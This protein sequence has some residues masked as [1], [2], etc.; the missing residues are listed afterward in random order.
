[1]QVEKTD[2]NRSLTLAQVEFCDQLERSDRSGQALW[3]PQVAAGEPAPDCVVF[4]KETGRF[5]VM[6]PPGQYSV[7]D[8]DWYRHDSVGGKTQVADLI[9]EAWQAAMQVRLAIKG[10]LGIGAY[11]IPVIIFNDME[12]NAGIM[13][14]AQ[15]RGV[16]VFFGQ[17]EVVQ[18]LVTL[19]DEEQ[20]QPQLGSRYIQKEVAVLRPASALK[21]KTPEKASLEIDDGRLVFQHVAVVNVYINI[22]NPVA[23]LS[24]FSA[25]EART[26]EEAFLEIGD[27][28][29]VIQQVDVVNVYIT[30]GPDASGGASLPDVQG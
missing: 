12:P 11:T 4:I 8:D 14:A 29:L 10:E 3:W 26:P 1:M 22:H 27:G 17:D 21:A 30:D 18:R 16:R 24:R 5:A 20:L 15:G 2:N 7:E 25:P 23:V 19:P 6:L 9:E 28:R 13:E